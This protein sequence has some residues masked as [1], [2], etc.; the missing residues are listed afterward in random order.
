MDKSREY[1]VLPP[2]SGDSGAEPPQLPGRPL[3]RPEFGHANKSLSIEAK[4]ILGRT[5]WQS[6]DAQSSQ[7]HHRTPRSL[8]SRGA[9]SLCSSRHCV[10]TGL[11]TCR[12]TPIRPAFTHM[13]QGP[14]QALRCHPALALSP[15][16]FVSRS[17]PVQAHRGSNNHHSSTSTNTTW[18]S[19]L[20]LKARSSQQPRLKHKLQRSCHSKCLWDS[21]LHLKAFRD[22]KANCTNTR[23]SPAKLK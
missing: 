1:K 11:H 17:R 3:F 21:E 13:G 4:R 22:M 23:P 18:D 14:Q 5:D 7:Q 20:R 16:V 2:S 9:N 10:V 19:Q 12:A 15:E 6:W 8:L